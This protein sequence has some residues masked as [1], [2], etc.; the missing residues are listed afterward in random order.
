VDN[1]TG[2]L[3]LAQGTSGSLATRL[4]VSLNADGTLKTTAVNN[5]MHLIDDHTDSGSFVRMEFGERIKLNT[6]AS[7]ANSLTIQ[8]DTMSNTTDFSTGQISLIGSDTIEWN[9]TAGKLSADVIYAPVSHFYSVVPYTTNHLNYKTTSGG[10]PYVSGTLRVYVNGIRLS[11]T[12]TTS[13][14]RVGVSTTWVSLMYTEILSSA[15][16]FQF[17]ATLLNTDVVQID[18]DFALI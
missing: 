16:T 6:V 8:V 1:S 4:N 3:E 10:T 5:S 2:I 7:N 17:N 11:E 18:F 15:G 14:P 13:V 9:Y 12:T